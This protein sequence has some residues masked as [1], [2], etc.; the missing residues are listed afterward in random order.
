MPK[1]LSFFT[2]PPYFKVKRCRGILGNF[3]RPKVCPAE[4]PL[5]SYVVVLRGDSSIRVLTVAEASKQTVPRRALP[6]LA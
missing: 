3:I 2:I 5:C 6:A 1:P 4:L